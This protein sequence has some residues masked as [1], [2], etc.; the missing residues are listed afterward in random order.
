VFRLITGPGIYYV[1]FL[2]EDA[3][4]ATEVLAHNI[5]FDMGM[6]VPHVIGFE[7]RNESTGHL[8]YQIPPPSSSFGMPLA[9]S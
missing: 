2:P 9:Q 6:I 1:R 8:L 3:S 7:H 5:L 4:F